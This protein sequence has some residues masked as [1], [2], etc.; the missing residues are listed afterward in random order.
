MALEFFKK[1]FD[2]FHEKERK[3]IL[4][5]RN[6]RVNLD[7]PGLDAPRHV[8]DIA[9]TL[10]QKKLLGVLGAHAV[11]AVEND[12]FRGIKFGWSTLGELA[13][14]NEPGLRKMAEIPFVLFPDIDE[15]ESFAP[16]ERGFKFGNIHYHVGNRSGSGTGVKREVLKM[17]E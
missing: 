11:V 14:G 10:G 15:A 9:K 13:E 7:G 12:F 3:H 4:V 1:G 2:E 8:P 17:I 6:G 5:A 16:V